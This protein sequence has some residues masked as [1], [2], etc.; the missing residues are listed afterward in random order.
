MNTLQLSMNTPQSRAISS[1][2]MNTQFIQ[3]GL[4]ESGN[5]IEAPQEVI[6]QYDEAIRTGDLP[7]I[8]WV[9]STYRHYE[10]P[11]LNTD[12]FTMLDN[13]SHEA[14]V[15]LDELDFT[16][17][18]DIVRAIVYDDPLLLYTRDITRDIVR[19][20][21]LRGAWE[22]FI[23][24]RQE[25]TRTLQEMCMNNSEDCRYFMSLLSEARPEEGARYDIVEELL[26]EPDIRR[27]YSQYTQ[28]QSK[29]LNYY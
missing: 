19:Q 18:P 3:D 16:V 8:D 7:F 15:W 17:L 29:D 6:N 22:I 13:A 25:I 4:D 20:I 2:I 12:P 23:Q 27:I 14:L 1:H 28:S 9:T 24:Y 10:V 26:R 5:E 11:I 21:L